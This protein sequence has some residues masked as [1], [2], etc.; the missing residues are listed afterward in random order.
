M[1]MPQKY[2]FYDNEFM[3]DDAG[4]KCLRAAGQWIAHDAKTS[5]FNNFSIYLL[6]NG[7]Y[8]VTLQSI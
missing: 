8:Y 6:C 4:A 1:C 7:Y 2:A 5:S 3:V